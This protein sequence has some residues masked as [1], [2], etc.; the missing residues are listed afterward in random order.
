MTKYENN[1]VMQLHDDFKVTVGEQEL[2]A[3][4]DSS[5]SQYLA[6][7]AKKHAFKS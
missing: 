4:S 3:P 5:Q 6:T 2:L 7:A 1:E